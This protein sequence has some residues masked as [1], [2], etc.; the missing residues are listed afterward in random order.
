MRSLVLM[1]MLSLSSLSFASESGELIA[2]AEALQEEARGQL[3]AW[4]AT[5]KFIEEAKAAQTAGDFKK[6]SELAERAIQLAQASLAQA[7]KEALSW[8]TRVPKSENLR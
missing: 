1:L 6:A 5:S 3:Y 7:K 8:H 4:V 2:K